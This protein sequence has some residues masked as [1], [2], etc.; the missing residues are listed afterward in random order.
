MNDTTGTRHDTGLLSDGELAML[1]GVAERAVHLAVARERIWRPDPQD[2][3]P[4]LRRPGAAFVTLRR[5][6]RLLGCVGT[7]AAVDPLVVTVAD[8]ARAAAFDDPR[9]PGIS[10]GDLP[11]LDVSVSVLS[12]LEPLE[13]HD[14]LDLLRT[15]RPGL[16]GLLVEAGSHRATLLPAVWHDLPE[17]GTFVGAL[18]H[19][20]GLEPGTWPAGIRVCRYTAQHAED[21]EPMGT[22]AHPG[23]VRTT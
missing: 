19:K 4:A 16:D 23:R 14:Y 3:P 11:E 13:P 2:Y 22:I 20:A 6:G 12:E 15:V 1:I 18:W 17:A 8:R 10:R 21:D 9:F 5:H 7:L